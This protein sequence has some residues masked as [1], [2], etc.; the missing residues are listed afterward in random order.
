VLNVDEIDHRRGAIF[1]FSLFCTTIENQFF[2]KQIS[3][4][5]KMV[6]KYVQF[7]VFFFLRSFEILF[8]QAISSFKFTLN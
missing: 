4:F 6:K 1:F 7:E 8:F 3:K 2:P 5:L